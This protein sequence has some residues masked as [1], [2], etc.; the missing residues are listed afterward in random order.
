M[1]V[2]AVGFL[3]Q[4][5][6]KSKGLGK[7]ENFTCVIHKMNRDGTFNRSIIT[8]P[9][10]KTT[11]NDVVSQTRAK[12][13]VLSSLYAITNSDKNTKFKGATIKDGIKETEI[14]SFISDKLF[15]VRTKDEDAKNHFRILGKNSTKKLLAKNLNIQ[16]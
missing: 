7:K 6:I 3:F 10:I 12:A 9:Y 4:N 11:T 13:D 8:S 2:S 16:V 15:A 14:H 1:K 5:N